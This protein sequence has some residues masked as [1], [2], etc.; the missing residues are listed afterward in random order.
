MVSAKSGEISD[1]GATIQHQPD[2]RL[3]RPVKKKRRPQ[4]QRPQTALPDSQNFPQ[5]ARD[6]SPGRNA[7]FRN[8]LILAQTQP[9]HAHSFR[10]RYSEALRKHTSLHFFFSFDV[11]DSAGHDRPETTMSD[12]QTFF[13]LCAQFPAPSEKK[14]AFQEKAPDDL[15]SLSSGA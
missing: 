3:L 11:A 5:E 4:T 6:L 10:L 14:R 9:N 1:A 15:F 7:G 13:E 8:F 2:M 12:F